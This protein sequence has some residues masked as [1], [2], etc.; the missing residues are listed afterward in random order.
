M[1]FMT[2]LPVDRRGEDNR[3]KRVGKR[4]DKKKTIDIPHVGSDEKVGAERDKKK[5][6]K[7]PHADS[8]E[9]L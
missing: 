3:M 1:T 5:T 8:D 7:S 6:I 4:R 9:K 2:L